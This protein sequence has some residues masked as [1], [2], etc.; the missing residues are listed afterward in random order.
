MNARHPLQAYFEDLYPSRSSS[1]GRLVFRHGEK[2]RIRIIRRWLPSV[3]GLT[4]LD[5]GCGDGVCLAAA[6]PDRPAQI[7]LEDLSADALHEAAARLAGSTDRLEAE[8][9]DVFDADSHDFDVVI[10]VGVLDYHADL[11]RALHALLL[12]TRRVLIVDVP[13]MS[14][15]RNWLRR[16]WFALRDVDFQLASLEQVRRAAAGC[17][18][19]FDI[20]RGPYEWF[21]RISVEGAPEGDRAGLPFGPQSA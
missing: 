10:A 3:R 17:G 1:W 12:R 5:A 19:P 11:P 20:E 6:L 16:A 14:H 7:R 15:P 18:H 9:V 4:V 2:E 8:V 13:R 21:L